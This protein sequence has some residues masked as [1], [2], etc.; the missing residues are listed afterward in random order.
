VS[1][2][3]RNCP[4]LFIALVGE[5]NRVGVSNGGERIGVFV[6]ASQIIVHNN[7]DRGEGFCGEHSHTHTHN[8]CSG[9]RCGFHCHR[10]RWAMK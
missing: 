6:V 10:V 7:N 3:M 4:P 9:Q 8:V 5:R 1:Y 2:G